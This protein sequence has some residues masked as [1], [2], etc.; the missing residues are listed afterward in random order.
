MLPK[1][2]R[3]WF[4]FLLIFFALF[5]VSLLPNSNTS[6]RA[7]TTQCNYPGLPIIEDPINCP[8]KNGPTT[9]RINDPTPPLTHTVKMDLSVSSQPFC[10]NLWPGLLKTGVV[11]TS[12]SWNT[13]SISDGNYWLNVTIYYGS[14]TG[15]SAINNALFSIHNSLEGLPCQPPNPPTVDIKANGSDNPPAINSGESVNVTWSS[16]NTLSCTVSPTGW[17]GKSGNQSE[18]LVES[19][20][21]TINCTGGNQQVTNDSVTVTVNSGSPPAN[22]PSGSTPPAGTSPPSG[23]SV[24]QTTSTT[25]TTGETIISP[26]TVTSQTLASTDKLIIEEDIPV[27]ISE[28]DPDIFLKGSNIKLN[29]IKN[30]KKATKNYIYFEG[31]TKPNTLVTLYIFSNP[32]IVTLKSDTKG[33][34]N[35]EREKRIDTGKHSAFAT[36]Y[37]DGVTRRSDVTGFFVAKNSKGNLVL[38]QTAFENLLFYGLIIGTVIA[39]S[40]VILIMYRIYISKKAQI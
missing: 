15:G 20:T 25:T 29:S 17:I 22:P 35:Y 26:E 38:K 14:G 4:G 27:S 40:I 34:W 1:K 3:T 18:N 13:T 23:S 2:L 39:F 31:K 21:Y 28:F 24:T 37:D 16:Y 10:K 32:I 30:I 7:Q 6:V 12:P 9:F 33:D 5:M 11:Y 19:K 8:V 36:I